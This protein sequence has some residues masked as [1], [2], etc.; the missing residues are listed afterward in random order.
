MAIDLDKQIGP[1]PLKV[2]LVIGVGGIGVGLYAAKHL[3]NSGAPSTSGI[4]VPAS[5][6]APAHMIGNEALPIQGLIG[7]VQDQNAALAAQVHNL[8][9]QS[10]QQT[11]T[12][13]YYQN[14]VRQ[15]TSQGAVAGTAFGDDIST[16]NQRLTGLMPK[17]NGI[18]STV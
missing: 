7:F 13:I 4:A 17:V 18:T 6:A 10:A 1:F 11:A 5:S 15:G 3:S 12:S 8:N 2:W 9:A 14:Q 16:I